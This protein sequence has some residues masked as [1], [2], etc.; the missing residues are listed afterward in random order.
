MV[1]TAEDHRNNHDADSASAPDAGLPAVPGS[2][3]DPSQIGSVEMVAAARQTAKQAYEAW[4]PRLTEVLEAWIG[5]LPEDA[6]SWRRGLVYV[7][8]SSPNSLA[9]SAPDTQLKKALAVAYR[10]QIRFEPDGLFFD[11]ETGTDIAPRRA[12]RRLLVLCLQP[13]GP[14]AVVVAAD[15]R[16]FRNMTQA[17]EI[18]RDFIRNG[19]DFVYEGMFEGDPRDPARFLH[20]SIH[21]MFAESHARNTSWMVGRHFETLSRDGRPVGR[22]P[23]VYIRDAVGPAVLG[24]QGS[25]LS[26]KLSEPLATVVKDGMALYLEGKSFRQVA[27]WSSTTSLAGVTPAG[28]VMAEKWWYEQL[29]NPKHAGY[30]FPTKYPGFHAELL[31]SQRRRRPRKDSELVPCILPALWDLATYRQL[32]EMASKRWKSPKRRGTY[33]T[34]LLSGIAYDANCGHRMQLTG[35]RHD[36]GRFTMVCGHVS[37]EG[38]HSSR[39]RADVAEKEL[40]ALFSKI[41]FGSNADIKAIEDELR[42]LNELEHVQ[43]Q[44]FKANPQIATVKQAV[45]LLTGAGVNV[46]R[47]ELERQLA[48]L[49]AA[50]QERLDAMKEPA[51]QFRKSIDYLKDWPRVWAIADIYNKNKLLRDAGVRVELG[52]LPSE[53]RKRAPMHVLSIA[54]DNPALAMALSVAFADASGTHDSHHKG[55]FSPDAGVMVPITLKLSDGPWSAARPSTPLRLIQGGLAVNRPDVGGSSWTRRPPLEYGSIFDRGGPWLSVPQFA[56][57][58]G[59]VKNVVYRWINSGAIRWKRLPDRGD[60]KGWYLIH[61]REL[62]RVLDEPSVKDAA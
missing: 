46:A 19:I 11:V 2:V 41:N 26:W 31:P 56:K 50:D 32:I 14:K 51:R 42:R 12:F 20:E 53:R 23:E 10:K 35:A 61:E 59:V 8:E 16:M 62:S 27:E 28:V 34:Y 33:R 4:L 36:D 55:D 54:A 48:D 43:R 7:R 38:A 5:A 40:D 30:Q 44:R 17:K 21:Q 22:I 25:V 58:A 9:K 29:K 60:R 6:Q 57:R 3:F 45:A 13:T 47:A 1:P 49:E 24:R 15:D 39:K 18:G 37:A 52:R